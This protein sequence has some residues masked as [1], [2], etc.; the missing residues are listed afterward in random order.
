MEEGGGASKHLQN[1]YTAVNHSRFIYRLVHVLILLGRGKKNPETLVVYLSETRTWNTSRFPSTFFTKEGNSHDQ[2]T[3]RCFFKLRLCEWE[4]ICSLPWR[5]PESPH[6]SVCGPDCSSGSPC[7]RRKKDQTN[8]DS[9]RKQEP[10]GLPQQE[11][12]F[13]S[14]PTELGSGSSEKNGEFNDVF[15]VMRSDP[16]FLW[17]TNGAWHGHV[18]SKRERTVMWV[19]VPRD[20]A[21]LRS[22]PVLHVFLWQTANIKNSAVSGTP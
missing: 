13:S 9:E 11:H 1:I 12:G 14:N 15:E 8:Q 3:I 16:V 10:A 2:S 17:W 22:G 7:C 20:I 4:Q 21:M 19:S 5:R 18:C 6:R